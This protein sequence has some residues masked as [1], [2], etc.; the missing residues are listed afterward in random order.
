MQLG[1][2]VCGSSLSWIE[3][4]NFAERPPPPFTIGLGCSDISPALHSLLICAIFLIEYVRGNTQRFGMMKSCFLP[5]AEVAV[6][7]WHPS[8][9]N[10][11]S[12]YRVSGCKM[13]VLM[14]SNMPCSQNRE[15]RNGEKNRESDREKG[16]G[17]SSIGYPGKILLLWLSQE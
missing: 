9:M 6:A 7:E 4:R 2:C 12:K 13:R 1:L 8:Q 14:P 3:I 16:I 5:F 10:L 15:K 17:I 11:W